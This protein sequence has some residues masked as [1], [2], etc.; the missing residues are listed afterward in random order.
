[1]TAPDSALWGRWR[2]RSPRRPAH[3]Q[4]N[5]AVPRSPDSLE[6]PGKGLQPV[7]RPRTIPAVTENGRYVFYPSAGGR[8]V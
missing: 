3:S 6:L 7:P 1:M 2:P 5:K 8:S 4:P